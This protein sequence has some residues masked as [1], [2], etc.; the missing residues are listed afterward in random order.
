[1]KHGDELACPHCGQNTFVIK[2]SVMDGWTKSG[3]MYACSACDAKIADADEDKELANKTTS[4]A[5][6]ALLNF[7]D[8]EKKEKKE[9]SATEDEG[10][11]CRDCGHLIS[12]PFLTRCILHKKDVNPMNDCSDFILRKSEEEGCQKE[13]KST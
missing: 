13:E 4:N 1:M 11:F 8:L 3:D 5:S 9:L 12:H 7:L 10:H 2:K 6:T